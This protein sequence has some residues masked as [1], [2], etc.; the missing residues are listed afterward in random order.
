MGA[1]NINEKENLDTTLWRVSVIYNITFF[2]PMCRWC[3]RSG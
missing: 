1:G 3:P 2:Y